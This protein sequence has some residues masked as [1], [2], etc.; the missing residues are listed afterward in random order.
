M[1]KKVR[2]QKQK[3]EI[4]QSEQEEMLIYENDRIETDE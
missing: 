3:N 2:R 1:E 4:Q